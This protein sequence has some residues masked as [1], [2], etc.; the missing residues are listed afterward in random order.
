MMMMIALTLQ[1]L[2]IYKG[3]ATGASGVADST[4]YLGN[5]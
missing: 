1:E 2:G 5:V 4:S 3:A